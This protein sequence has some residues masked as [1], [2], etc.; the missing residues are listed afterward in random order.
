MRAYVGASARARVYARASV[1]RHHSQHSQQAEERNEEMI[2]E[3]AMRVM[4]GGVQT[5]ALIPEAASARLLEFLR[6]HP[7]SKKGTA[8]EVGP[9]HPWS[10]ANR[11]PRCV[12]QGDCQRGR[13]FWQSEGGPTGQRG[14]GGNSLMLA[15]ARPSAGPNFC[16]REFQR[17]GIAR[18]V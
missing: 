7:K 17:G 14:G 3:G 2:D 6:E 15:A 10:Y 5:S 16:E 9:S 4:R 18:G 11:V 8:H 1:S 12:P 13:K